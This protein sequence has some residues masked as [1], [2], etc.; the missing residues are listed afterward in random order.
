MTHTLI[1]VPFEKH[2]IMEG[3]FVQLD[4]CD[5]LFCIIVFFV[6]PCSLV[7]K[8]QT[9]RETFASIIAADRGSRLICTGA[10]LPDYTALQ[11]ATQ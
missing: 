11:P 3:I 6:M 2:V 4:R 8:H 5:V 10:F 9:F 7:E 1:R